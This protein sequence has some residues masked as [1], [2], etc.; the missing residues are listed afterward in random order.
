MADEHYLGGGLD[1]EGWSYHR[2]EVAQKVQG[3]ENMIII[4]RYCKN[5]FNCR[6]DTVILYFQFNYKI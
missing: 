4:L 1:I 6:Y 5:I 3:N 2:H